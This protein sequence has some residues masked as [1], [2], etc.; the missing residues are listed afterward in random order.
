MLNLKRRAVP[1]EENDSSSSDDENDEYC[2]C[3]VRSMMSVSWSADHRVIDG[4]TM[5]RFSNELKFLLE[6]PIHLLMHQ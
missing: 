4:A 6:N 5:A 1:D 3:R 2:S